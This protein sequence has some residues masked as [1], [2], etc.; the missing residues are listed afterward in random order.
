MR[1][2]A[3]HVP[4]GLLT[5]SPSP[6][7]RDRGVPRKPT[8]VWTLAGAMLLAS[9]LL[10]LSSASGFEARLGESGGDSMAVMAGVAGVLLAAGIVFALRWAW[11]GAM[12]W[13]CAVMILELLVYA[14]AQ[15]L[16]YGV[17]ALS[18][19]QVVL[20]HMSDVKRALVPRAASGRGP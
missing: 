2:S 6:R 17:M 13:L 5:R 16:A 18:I 20:L 11:T 14:S 10:I 15:T 1:L 8:L 9:L 7:T 4:R 3:V 12:A 19:L